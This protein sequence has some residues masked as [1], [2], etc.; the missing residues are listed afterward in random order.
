MKLYHF[1]ASN[2]LR[3][4][5]TAGLTVGDVPTDQ[6]RW[7]GRI[8]VWL[9]RDPEAAGHGLEGSRDDKTRYRLAVELS[10]DDS[11]LHRWLDWSRRYVTKE[12]RDMLHSTA[13]GFESWFV[14]FGHIKPEAIVECTDMATG[15]N[16]DDWPDR[17]PASFDAPAVPYSRRAAWH[18]R[19]IKR[20]KKEVRRRQGAR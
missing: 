5:A 14:Y 10:G 3:P 9:T 17:F 18:K 6:R 2:R 13:P 1:T 11:R 12:T 20:V 4:I 15:E 8:G 16:L 7:K 19:L